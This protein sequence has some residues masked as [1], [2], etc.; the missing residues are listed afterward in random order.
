[1][2]VVLGHDDAQRSVGPA[3]RRAVPREGDDRLLP[4]ELLVQLCYRERHDV[5]VRTFG[6]ESQG[7]GWASERA[8]SGSAGLGR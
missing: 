2:E 8:S 1:M 7:H 6:Q 3:D 4:S 5:A